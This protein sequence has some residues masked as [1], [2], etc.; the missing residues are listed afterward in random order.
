MPA[1]LAGFLGSSAA[2]AQVAAEWMRGSVAVDGDAVLGKEA[3]QD[4]IAG[5]LSRG[6]PGKAVF[7]GGARHHGYGHAGVS[8][9][10]WVCCVCAEWKV[11]RSGGADREGASADCSS[12]AGGAEGTALRSC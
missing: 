2:L 11:E 5:E 1:L 4:S 7:A 12:A 8:A 6:N 9:A 10:A 3:A